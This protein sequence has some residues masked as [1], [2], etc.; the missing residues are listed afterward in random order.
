M[1]TTETI[2]ATSTLSSAITKLVNSYIE[3]LGK[4]AVRNLRALTLETIEPIVLQTVL[5]HARYNQSKAAK[6]LGMSRGTL[7]TRLARYFGDAYVGKRSKEAEEGQE[8][9]G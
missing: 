4:D 1:Q 6:H 9:H 7:R 5:E 8:R 2:E 3:T